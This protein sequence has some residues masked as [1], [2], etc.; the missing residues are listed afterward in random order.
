MSEDAQIRRDNLA[1]LQLGPKELTEKLG[2]TY[3][4]WRDLVKSNKS[5]GEKLAR[6]IEDGLELPR[7][8]LDRPPGANA[9]E[10]RSFDTKR[11]NGVDTNNTI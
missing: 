9:E 4:F 8:W 6:S 10:R 3:S 7:G 5:F 1:T 2:R 11:S